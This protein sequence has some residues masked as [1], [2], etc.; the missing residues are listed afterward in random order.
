MEYI[1]SA[2]IMNL[3]NLKGTAKLTEQGEWVHFKDSKHILFEI[4]ENQ[5]WKGRTSS[6][7][8]SKPDL[9]IW[10]ARLAGAYTAL[11]CPIF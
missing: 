2:L 5:T 3:I 4:L 11:P 7:R 8:L 1:H 10:L 9:A 6:C